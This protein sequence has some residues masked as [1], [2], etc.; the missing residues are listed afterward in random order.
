MGRLVAVL[1]IVVAEL[2][3]AQTWAATVTVV[4]TKNNTAG[5]LRQAIQ[6]AKAGD[7]IKFA[8]PTTDAG[9]DPVERTFTIDVAGSELAIAKNLT[10]DGENQRVVLNRSTGAAPPLFRVLHVTA[11]TVAITGGLTI[12][13]GYTD[14]DAGGAGLFNE[15]TLALSG[16]TV[17]NNFSPLQPGGG[18]ENS[19]VLTVTGCTIAGNS[20]EIGGGAGVFNT[21]N[22]DLTLVNCTIVRNTIVGLN[23]SAGAGI[24]NSGTAHVQSTVVALN[25]TSGSD[26]DLFGDFLSDGYNFVGTSD[27]STGFGHSGSHDQVGTIAAP[28]DPEIGDVRDNGGSTATALPNAGS[29][30]VDQGSS[31][32]EAT[33]QIG[34]P[35]VIDDP[36]VANAGGGDGSDIGAAERDLRQGGSPYYLVTT[37]DERSDGLCGENDCTLIEAL[38]I[39][40]AAGTIDTI[41]FKAGLSGTITTSRLTPGGL[42]VSSPVTIAGPGARQLTISGNHAARVFYVTDAEATIARLTIADGVDASAGGAIFVNSELT[43]IDCTVI[44]SDATGP[45]GVGG[46]IYVAPSNVLT[47]MNCTVTGNTAISDGGGAYNDGGTLTAIDSTFF[48][49]QSFSDFG[50]AIFNSG[51]VTSLVGSTVTENTGNGLQNASGSFMLGNSL[52][53]TNT[54]SSGNSPDLIGAFTSAGYNLVGISDGTNDLTDGVNHDLVGSVAT[55]LDPGLDI[56]KGLQNN[57]GPTDTIALLADSV[58]IDAA[59]PVGSSASDQRHFDRVGAPDIGAYEFGG[60]LPMTLANISTRARVETGDDVLIGGFIVT[61][62]HSKQ[63]L[64]RALG[65]SLSLPGKLTDPILELHDVAGAVLAINDNWENSAN[66]QAIIDTTIP[67]TDPSESAILQTL[68]PGTYTAIVRGMN[69]ETGIALIEAYDLD[70]TTDAKFANISTRGSVQTGDDVMIGGFIVLGSQNERV[71]VRAIGPSLPV[72]GKLSDPTLELHDSNG[73]LFASNDN[74]RDTQEDEIIFTGIPPLNDAESA[75]VA[76][77]TPGSYTAIVRGLDNTQGVALV[78]AYGLD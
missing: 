33:D 77:L 67:P 62:T 21:A 7:T 26:R 8:I 10:I 12:V 72:T 54:V 19:G 14:T 66:K 51:G 36:A 23:Q 30:L 37:T 9:Y 60:T 35:R 15:G 17:L 27:G 64:L 34:L 53:A 2:F 61:G 16:C 29:P 11:G 6:D 1:G 4:N 52:V 18:I 71:I 39:A 25:T 41:V 45:G 70:R 20:T 57:G 50:G 28:I 3:L 74:W 5:S 24:Q 69:N 48:A 59:N 76:T 43:L 78:E 75:I 73:F 22:C 31:G 55:P 42:P 46:G 65:P 38:D 49:N 68:A 44:G 47:M 56:S 40:N 58:A 13:G 32:G 63:V